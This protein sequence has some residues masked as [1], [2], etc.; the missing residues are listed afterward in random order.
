MHFPSQHLERASLTLQLVDL[1]IENQDFQ[2]AFLKLQSASQLI[3]DN[4]LLNDAKLMNQLYSLYGKIYKCREE[5][6][7]SLSYYQ[8]AFNQ[9]QQILNEQSDDNANFLLADS[10]KRMARAFKQKGQFDE[11]K[12][13]L[14]L[15]L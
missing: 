2:D 9:T 13:T 12:E 1:L 8:E 11:S 15:Y 10:L 7:K 4:N 5:P 6:Q 3:Q 14:N